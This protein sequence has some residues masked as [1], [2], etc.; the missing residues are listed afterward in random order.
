[1][2]P[3]LATEQTM[4]N[5]ELRHERTS[6]KRARNSYRYYSKESGPGTVK[7]VLYHRDGGISYFDYQT[8]KRGIVFS[9]TVVD[10]SGGFERS[11]PMDDCNGNLHLVEL[12]AYSAK[13]LEKAAEIL[14][15][16]LPEFAEL[17]ADP[18]QRQ[19]VVN[20]VAELVSGNV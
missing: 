14:D 7:F 18:D 11:S 8:K 9:V 20:R 10:L 17:W 16:H 12:N 13:K 3:T 19:N 4:E 15:P 2:L 1:M 5:F 6:K